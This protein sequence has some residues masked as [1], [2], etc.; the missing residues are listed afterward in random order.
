MD[1]DVLEKLVNQ[2]LSTRKIAVQLC[3]S[4]STVKHWLGKYNLNTICKSGPQPTIPRNPCRYCG[5]KVN[6]GSKYYCDAKC[7]KKYEYDTAI[8]AWKNGEYP[9]N[10]HSK[11]PEPVR[12]YLFQ[13]YNHSCCICGWD[14]INFHTKSKVSPLEVD[15]IDGDWR[16]NLEENLR[17]LCPNCHS[18]TSTYRSLNAGRGRSYKYY[19]YKA[20]VAQE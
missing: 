2:R 12:T 7:H 4:Q 1:K 16:N 19:N 8:A 6:R 9:P 10:K 17:L 15:H 3:C 11:V 5:K 14:K 20:L 13:K 18:L